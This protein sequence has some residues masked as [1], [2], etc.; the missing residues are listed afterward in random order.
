MYCDDGPEYAGSTL[1]A[2]A[3]KRG[4]KLNCI[5]PSNPQQCLYRAIQPDGHLQMAVDCLWMGAAEP[6]AGHGRTSFYLDNLIR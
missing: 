5:P 3:Q 4:I 6:A 2:L 1:L